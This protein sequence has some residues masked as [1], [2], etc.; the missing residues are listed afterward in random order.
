MI[1][2]SRFGF[3][4]ADF[5]KV[6]Y[7]AAVAL[8]GRWQNFFGHGQSIAGVKRQGKAGDHHMG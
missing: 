7:K 3:L 4:D 1:D 6:R 5:G 2:A 8:V